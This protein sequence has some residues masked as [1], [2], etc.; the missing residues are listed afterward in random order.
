MNTMVCLHGH[1][2][3]AQVSS[4]PLQ[5]KTCNLVYARLTYLSSFTDDLSDLSISSL[6]DGPNSLNQISG[7]SDLLVFFSTDDIKSL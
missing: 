1:L 6:N 4:A 2:T 5:K 3:I 7:I